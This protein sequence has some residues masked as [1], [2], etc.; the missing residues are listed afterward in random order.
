MPKAE[1]FDSSVV[2]TQTTSSVPGSTSLPRGIHRTVVV[3]LVSL[4]LA[5]V[6]DHLLASWLGFSPPPRGYIGAYRRVGPQAGPQVFCAGSSLTV[7]ALYW[8]EVS[9]ALGQGIQTWSVAGSSP[10]IWEEWQQQSPRSTTTII[11]ISVYDL[12]ELHVAPDRANIVPL[13]QTIKDLWSTHPD[14]GLSHRLLTQ[15][16][17]RYVEL[18]FPTAGNSD[19]VLVAVRTKVADLLGR[20]V[21]LAQ[22]EGVVAEPSPPALAAGESTSNIS[23]W[24]SGRLLRRIAVLRDENRGRHEFSNGPKHMAFR[25]ML[26][27]ARQRGKVIVVVLP[28]AREYS[29]AFLDDSSLA[30]FEREIHEATAIA[31]EATIVRLDRVPGISNPSYFLDLAH[32]NSLGRRVATESFLMEVTH[33]GSQRMLDAASSASI[34]SGK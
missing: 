20:Q 19:R 28:V 9:Q 32:M 10:D 29:E 2:G 13:S 7:S 16:A 8:S 27:L 15:Y 21:S 30:A 12:N 14:S 34:S 17:L 11:G 4:V 33:G 26:L 3:F 23:E 24:S 18:F 22:H 25:R 6:A 31:P 5:S 1:T